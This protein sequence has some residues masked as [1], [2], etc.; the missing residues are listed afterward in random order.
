MHP[1][2][3]A[4][5]Q[6]FNSPGVILVRRV[7]IY[8]VSRANFWQYFFRSFVNFTAIPLVVLVYVKQ[9]L[10]A[11]FYN[12]ST[13]FKCLSNGSGKFHEVPTL[14]VYAYGAVA[15]DKP[16]GHIEL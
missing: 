12:F 1:T 2:Y 13:F 7:R 15:V 11:Q 14:K 9:Y 5:L 8:I 4:G 3:F 16:I 6:V 10:Y